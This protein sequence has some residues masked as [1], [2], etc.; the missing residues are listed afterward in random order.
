[1]TTA[2]QPEKQILVAGV[3]NAWLRDDAFGGACARRL[4]AAGVPDG[5]TVM[6]FGT[7]GLDLAYELMR[8]Y[9][10][11]VLLDA[12]RQGGEP[13]TLYV[14]EPD[15]EALRRPIEDGEAIDPHGMDPRTVLRFVGAIGGFNGRVVVVGCEPGAVDDVGLGLTPAVAGAVDRA[16][17]LVGE[18]LDELRAEA[19]HPR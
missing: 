18:T 3:G 14:V 13:G 6:D 12:T 17:A 7:G 1:M 5:V 9:D 2:R 15:M 8:G 10:A 4:A 11:L 16:L 19:A